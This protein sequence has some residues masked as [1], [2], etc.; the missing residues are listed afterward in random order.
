MAEDGQNDSMKTLLR[1]SILSLVALSAVAPVLVAQ[2]GTP[3]KAPAVA[4]DAAMKMLKDGNRRFVTGKR[5][6]PNQNLNRVKMTSK[7]QA[8]FVTILTCADSR[9][10][11]ELLF[12]R[13]IGDLFIIRVAGNVA[14]TSEIGTIEY[15]TKHLGSRLLVVMGHTKCGAVDAVVNGANVS[16]NIQDL[17]K[18]IVPAAER[19]AAKNPG[20]SKAD[21]V[22][23]AINENVWHSI[24]DLLEKSPT[25]R[26]LVA[27]GKLR[28]EAAVYDLGNGKV[29]F[30]GAHPRQKELVSGVKISD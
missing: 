30:M 21:L 7:G 14:A 23:I 11:P 18:P 12:D 8:P 2:A 29:N 5:L 22:P 9:V 25:L 3:S 19:A 15:G 10:A 1:T 16:Q 28:I 26:E 4:P 24:E 13:G 6:R 27:T 20:K 17:V